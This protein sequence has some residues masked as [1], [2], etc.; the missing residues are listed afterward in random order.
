LAP[1]DPQTAPQPEGTYLAV[2]Q[3][4]QR[5]DT[6]EH[7]ACPDEPQ[8]APSAAQGSP[9][10]S[11]SPPRAATRSRAA[12]SSQPLRQVHRG[13]AAPPRLARDDPQRAGR[14]S[15]RGIELR[16]AARPLRERRDRCSASRTAA[17]PSKPLR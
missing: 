13:P 12:R 17:L 4:E 5:L 15:L 6:I 11:S 10:K 2:A 9:G 16:E 14:E 7:A 1:T 3:A 8:P